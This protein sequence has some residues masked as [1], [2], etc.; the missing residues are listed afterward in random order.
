MVIVIIGILVAIGAFLYKGIISQNNDKAR[1]QDVQQWANTF[2]L[3]QTKNGVYPVMPVS[4]SPNKDRY[5]LGDVAYFTS[6]YQ[7][8]CGQYTVN[9]MSPSKTTDASL[10][11]DMNTRLATVGNLPTNGGTD[12]SSTFVGPL[13]Y[14]RQSGTNPI[15]VE[16]FFVSFFENSCPSNLTVA[17][18]TNDS[19]LWTNI[20]AMVSGSGVTAPTMCYL[21]KSFTYIP[22]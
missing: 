4:G 9:G 7:G 1:L 2:E 14:V 15:K 17:N 3:Y 18:S 8:K 10:S 16:A 19:D 11:T 20:N 13:V 6:K 22:G 21:K 12:V 5:C